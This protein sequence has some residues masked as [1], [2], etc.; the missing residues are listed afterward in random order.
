MIKFGD[1]AKARIEQEAADTVR[2]RIQFRHND[3]GRKEIDALVS[4]FTTG[5]LE[6]TNCIEL[7]N[8]AKLDDNVFNNLLSLANVKNN[9]EEINN[10]QNMAGVELPQ[11]EKK[12]ENHLNLENVSDFTKDGKNYIKMHY[13]DGTIKI[14]E[15]NFNASGKE[16]FGYIQEKYAINNNDGVKNATDIFEG[17][18]ETCHEVKLTNIKNMTEEEYSNIK[19]SDKD[20]LNVIKR[21]YEQDNEKVNILASPEENIY[22]VQLPNKD[23]KTISV[24]KKD[25]IYVIYDLEEKGYKHDNQDNNSVTNNINDEYVDADNVNGLDDEN[26]TYDKG[27]DDPT[28]VNKKDKVKVLTLKRQLPNSMAGY[29]DAALLSL[30]VGMSS[31]SL[32]AILIKLITR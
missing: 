14:I 6:F 5:K 8:R 19:S 26:I 15:N 10:I 24:E 22:I 20:K 28:Y 23:E 9:V 3:I 17:L 32:I 1:F 13:N 29:M 21:K 2:Y 4:L 16:I 25:G 7:I 12:D 27:K 18:I 30:I 31:A 11:E